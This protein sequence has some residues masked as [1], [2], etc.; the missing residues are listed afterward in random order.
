MFRYICPSVLAGGASSRFGEDKVLFVFGRYSFLDSRLNLLFDVGFVDV[1]VGGKYSGYSCFF[2]IVKN[3]GPISA[4][5]TVFFSKFVN[6]FLCFLFVPVDVCFLNTSFILYFIFNYNCFY[7][8]FLENF[9]LPILLSISFSVYLLL[10]KF[11][12]FLEKFFFS[13]QTLLLFILSKCCNVHS[14]FRFYFFNFNIS[15][16]LLLCVDYR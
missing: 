5:L 3:C 6:K 2:D 10:F 4:L 11:C 12:F 8:S 9:L 7:S 13:I 1:Y 15:Y 16:N 14:F